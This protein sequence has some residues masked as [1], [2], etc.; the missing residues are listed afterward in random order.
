MCC[1]PLHLF[2]S[3][4]SSL[5]SLKGSH[6]FQKHMYGEKILCGVNVPFTHSCIWTQTVWSQP[7]KSFISIIWSITQAE[8][9]RS[10]YQRFGNWSGLRAWNLNASTAVLWYQYW[11]KKFMCNLVLSS[12]NNLSWTNKLICL[13]WPLNQRILYCVYVLAELPRDFSLHETAAHQ[14]FNQ[15][16]FLYLNLVFAFSC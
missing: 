3:C 10:S 9:L 16:L 5:L 8:K 4:I 1:L 6:G 7:L 11:V 13:L 2:C 14:L 15:S 12:H